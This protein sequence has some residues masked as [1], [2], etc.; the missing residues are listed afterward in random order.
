MGWTHQLL[1]VNKCY[2]FSHLDHI[3]IISATLQGRDDGGVTILLSPTIP[4]FLSLRS[5]DGR[6]TPMSLHA[7]RM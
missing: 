7:E 4:S 1:S 2:T 5:R 6:E 3:Y